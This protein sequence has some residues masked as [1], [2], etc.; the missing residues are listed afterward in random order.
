MGAILTPWPEDYD[1]VLRAFE[2]GAKFGK[3][4]GE[5]LLRWRDHA[6]RLSRKDRRYRRNAFLE[7]KAFYLANY[8]KRNNIQEVAIWGAGPT[9]LKLN[10]CL[11][12]NGVRVRKFYDISPKLAGRLKRGKK[13]DVADLP[14]TAEFVRSMFRPTLIAI[15]ARGAAQKMATL[16]SDHGMMHHKDFIQLS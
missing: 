4:N 10:D 7:C 13:I 14:V 1:L 15:S 5:A 12:V 6:T 11:E 9:G 2:K 8:L 16:L 3:P